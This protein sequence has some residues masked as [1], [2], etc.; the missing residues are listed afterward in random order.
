MSI[1]RRRTRMSDEPRWSSS[2]NY[3]DSSEWQDHEHL[4]QQVQL[5]A[6]RLV[7]SAGTP[8]LAKRAVDLARAR[9]PTVTMDKDEFARALGYVSYLD[10]FEASTVHTTRDGS[11]LCVTVMKHGKWLVWDKAEMLVIGEFDST[12]DAL[13]QIEQLSG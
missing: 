2:V 12:E 13:R 1:Y 6:Q 8:E 4:S 3:D 10:L 9:R 5:D 11:R 7:E